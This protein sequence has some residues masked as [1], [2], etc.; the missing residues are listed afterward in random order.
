[1]NSNI[2]LGRVARLAL[3]AL[4]CGQLAVRADHGKSQ[5]QNSFNHYQQIN[6]VSDIPGMALL[7]DPDLVNAWGISFGPTSPFWI[8][9]NGSGKSTLYSVTYNGAGQPVVAKPSL[10]VTIPGAGNP[11][12]QLFNGSGAFNGD[13]FIFASEDGTVSGW[14]PALGTAPGTAA[15][16]L[17][18]PSDAIY[19]GIT[20]VQTSKGPMLLAANFS[21]G[22]VDAFDPSL[23]VTHYADPNAPAGYAPFN[24]GVLGGVVFVTFAKREGEDDVAGPGHGFI[25]IF[26]PENGQFMRFATGSDAGGHLREINSPWGMA[27]AP[28]SFGKHA[29]ELLVGNFGS[30]TIM[31]FDPYSR[32]FKGLLQGTTGGHVVIDGLWAL[33]F[34]NG[35][36]GG[37]PNTLYFTAGPNEE[38][39]GLFGSLD[40]VKGNEDDDDGNEDDDHGGHGH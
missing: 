10:F 3:A 17:V 31:T 29:G 1:M 25:D 7:T 11:T 38:S 34:G 32:E 20:L 23:T 30:G 21:A 39:H 14:R 9:D 37:R 26:N 15:E 6:L 36:N 35:G 18:N 16:T 5:K 27:W 12:G 8:S 4:L 2:L 13:I 24:V 33:T 22:K 40:P 28:A 19:K